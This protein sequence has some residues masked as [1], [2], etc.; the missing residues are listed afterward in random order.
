M[1]L[2]MT[3]DYDSQVNKIRGKLIVIRNWVTTQWSN[4]KTDH[5]FKIMNKV[6]HQNLDACKKMY[7][8]PRA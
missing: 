8:L 1:I 2:T 5:R 6:K 4:L 3:I 7:C